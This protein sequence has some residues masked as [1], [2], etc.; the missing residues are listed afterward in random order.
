MVP[1]KNI[2]PDFVT[3]GG[4]IRSPAITSMDLAKQKLI[5]VINQ[6]TLS[7]GAQADIEMTDYLSADYK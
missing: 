6:T 7:H 1:S 3:I 4:T 2:T 5:D